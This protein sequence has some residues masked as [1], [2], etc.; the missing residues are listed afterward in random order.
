MGFALL[1]WLL[2]LPLIVNIT[3]R[4]ASVSR[5]RA[6]VERARAQVVDTTR[7][8]A[9]L[10]MALEFARSESFVEYWARTQQRWSRAGE[11]VVVVPDTA[12]ST[13]VWWQPFLEGPD[14]P[15]RN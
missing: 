7:H 13:T 11:V 3:G 8:I 15:P 12:F 1:I 6:E 2:L 4:L 9:N 14:S 5:A 10:K